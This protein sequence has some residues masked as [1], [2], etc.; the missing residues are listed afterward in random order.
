MRGEPRSCL[1]LFCS[2]PDTFW[3]NPQFLLSVWKPQEGGMFLMPCS[4]LVSLLQKP[5]HRN[6]NRKPHFAIGFYLFRVGGLLGHAVSHGVSNR[7]PLF[8]V[9]CPLHHLS[10]SIHRP[11]CKS[12]LCLLGMCDLEQVI[13]LHLSISF[14]ICKM[15]TMIFMQR[16]ELKVDHVSVLL[17]LLGT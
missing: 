15:G 13:S 10:L 11:G 17:I 6:R 2:A 7:C 9:S 8:P 4:V 1:T 14:F 16:V 5:R 3:K 12:W